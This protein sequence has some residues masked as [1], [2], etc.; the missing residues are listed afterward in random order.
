MSSNKLEK[1]HFLLGVF[2]EEYFNFVLYRVQTEKLFYNQ[3]QT[4]HPR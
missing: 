2:D 4:D 1:S 3:E